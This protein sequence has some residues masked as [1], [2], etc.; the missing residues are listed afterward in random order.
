M[1]VCAEKKNNNSHML[2]GAQCLTKQ[3]K[4]LEDVMTKFNYP[5]ST[6]LNSTVLI[7]STI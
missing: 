3:G 6:F 4:T 2:Q 5:A 1:L 7:H